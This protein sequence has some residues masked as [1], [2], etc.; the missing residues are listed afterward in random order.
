MTSDKEDEITWQGP[1]FVDLSNLLANLFYLRDDIIPIVRRAGVSPAKVNFN[2][3]SSNIWMSALE[4]ARRMGQIDAVIDSALEEYPNEDALKRARSGTP[5]KT[6][7]APEPDEWR[8]PRTVVEYQRLMHGRSTLVPVRYLERGMARSRAVV[9]IV[10]GDGGTG[11]G[12]LT[13]TNLLITNHHVLADRDQAR[14]AVIWFNYEETSD[15]ATAEIT[16]AKLDLDK[17]WMADADDDVSAWSFALDMT[18]D[19]GGLA[20]VKTSVVKGDR[21]NIIQHPMGAYKQ[22]SVAADLIADVRDDRIQ[23]LTDTQEGSSGAPVFDKY[24]NLVAVHHAVVRKAPDGSDLG[25]HRNQGIPVRR[26]IDKLDEASR[27]GGG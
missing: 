8:G 19:W 9:R 24:W 21:V 3:T 11:T 14:S 6:P 5:L 7:Q 22:L 17:F 15:Q 27:S 18:A 26:L 16:E 23:Y 12:F 4:E 2:G 25:A 13:D 10:T 20:L 1:E